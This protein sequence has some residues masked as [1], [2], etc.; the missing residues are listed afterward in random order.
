[1]TSEYKTKKKPYEYQNNGF[2]K[3]DSVVND[4][5]QLLKSIKLAVWQL[6]AVISIICIAVYI[7]IRVF[8]T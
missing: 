2:Q 4:M 3:A 7:V 5:T 6:L 8:S 1:I